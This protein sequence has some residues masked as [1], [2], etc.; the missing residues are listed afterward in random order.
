M[1]PGR[2]RDPKWGDIRVSMAGIVSNLILAAL[3]TVALAAVVRVEMSTG[4][5][6][7]VMELLRLAAYYGIFINLVLAFFNLIPIPPLDGSHVLFHLL[8]RELGLRYREAGR[9]GLLIV[10]GLLFFVPEV[11]VYLLWPVTMLLGAADAF[12]RLWI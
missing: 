2:Y 1:N 8:P 6:G 7:G 3:A 12:V 10:M 5:L 9:Y 11:F 4:S